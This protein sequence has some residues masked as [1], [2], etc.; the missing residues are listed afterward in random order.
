MEK[1]IGSLEKGKLADIIVID[2][3]PLENILE[4]EN[5][6]YTMINGRLYNAETM[7]EVGSNKKRT[8]FY[9]EMEGSGNAY[10][11]DIKSQSFMIPTCHC[12]Q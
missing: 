12:R 8:R 1:E 5:V 2:G 9:W 3:D 7:N 10:P 4:T 11:F 6:V